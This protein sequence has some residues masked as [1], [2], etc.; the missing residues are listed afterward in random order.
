MIDP[1]ASERGI[2]TVPLEYAKDHRERSERYPGGGGAKLGSNTGKS[3]DI[4]WRYLPD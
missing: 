2:P 4:M 3:R 1:S